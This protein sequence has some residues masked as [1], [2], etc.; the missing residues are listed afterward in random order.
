[1]VNIVENKAVLEIKIL[2]VKPETVNNYRQVEALLIK[3]E[4]VEGFP[5]LA[6]LN[7]GQKIIIH[8]RPEVASQL[9]SIDLKPVRIIAKKA[10]AK[11]FYAEEP[12]SPSL[13]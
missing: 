8:F 4:N 3:S 1:M 7:E 11:E 6:R 9:E 13:R 12:E 2:K 10:Y 5:N